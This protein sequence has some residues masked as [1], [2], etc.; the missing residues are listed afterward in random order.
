M[1]DNLLKM[2]TGLVIEYEKLESRARSLGTGPKDLVMATS[3][4]LNMLQAGLTYDDLREIAR[5]VASGR[6]RPQKPER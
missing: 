5:V 4:T 2:A 3:A 6:F 1:N